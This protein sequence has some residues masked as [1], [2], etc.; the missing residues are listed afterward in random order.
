MAYTRFDPFRDMMHLQDSLVRAFDATY[1]RKSAPQEKDDSSGAW[2]PAVD[3]FEDQDGL[4][5]YVELPGIDLKDIDV[6]VEGNTLTLRGERKLDREQ[7]RNGYRLIERVHG[8]F[9]RTFA[10]PET[11]DAEHVSAEAKDGVLKIRLPKKAE[12]KPRQIKVQVDQGRLASGPT[13]KQ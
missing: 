11:V 7:D 3:V 1:G 6:R 4:Q 9:F 5:L 8:S 2:Q 10:L 13:G 12:S